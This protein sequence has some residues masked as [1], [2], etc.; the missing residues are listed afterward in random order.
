MYFRILTRAAE[1]AHERQFGCTALPKRLSNRPRRLE[2]AGAG[3]T[4]AAVFGAAA[5]ALRAKFCDLKNSS[6]GL[7]IL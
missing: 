5:L 2:P 3:N 7:Y 6:S 1:S 4:E